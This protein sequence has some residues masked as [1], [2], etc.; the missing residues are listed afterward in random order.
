MN[1]IQQEEQQPQRSQRSRQLAVACK[2]FDVSVDIIY[3]APL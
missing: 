3:G 2:L 1:D